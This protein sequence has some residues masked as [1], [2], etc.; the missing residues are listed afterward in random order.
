M[1][2]TKG[3][4]KLSR[5]NI[6]KILFAVCA[7]ED[8]SL[9][10]YNFLS[11][12]FNVSIK[13]LVNFMLREYPTL[14]SKW[15]LEHFIKADMEVN[16]YNNTRFNNPVTFFEL[17]S[18]MHFDVCFD[19]WDIYFLADYLSKKWSKKVG[20]VLVDANSQVSGLVQSKDYKENRFLCDKIYYNINN[21]IKQFRPKVV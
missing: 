10:Y 21:Y 12:D 11:M 14:Y 20:E 17:V 7:L 13:S 1:S 8:K 2:K 18:M 4:K 16:G 5:H 19:F 9:S 6:F 15:E 3:I